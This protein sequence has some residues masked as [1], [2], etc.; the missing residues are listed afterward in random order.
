MEQS[1]CWD[2]PFRFHLQVIDLTLFVRYKS[3]LPV[4]HLLTYKRA[5]F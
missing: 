2:F 3:D 4:L 1:G 5:L